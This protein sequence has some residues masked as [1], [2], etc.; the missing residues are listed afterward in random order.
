MDPH[1]YDEAQY[2]PYP[3]GYDPSAM[4]PYYAPTPSV[5]LR[6]PV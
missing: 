6:Q 2:A 4:D 1:F 3:T 5:F